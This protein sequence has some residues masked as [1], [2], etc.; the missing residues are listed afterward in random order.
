MTSPTI[1]AYLPAD[2]ARRTREHA[3]ATGRSLSSIVVEALGVYFARVD[4]YE[5]IERIARQDAEAAQ[6]E[7]IDMETVLRGLAAISTAQAQAAEEA[8]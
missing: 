4:A 5:A 7:P 8:E 2:I 1:A 3:R 6:V